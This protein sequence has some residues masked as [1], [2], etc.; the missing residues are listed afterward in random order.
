MKRFGSWDKG[1]RKF[2]KVKWRSLALACLSARLQ[3]EG[4]AV[5]EGARRVEHGLKLAAVYT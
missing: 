4:Q 2:A 1:S 3:W 5:R